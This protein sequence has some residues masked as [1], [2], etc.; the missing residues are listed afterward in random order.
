MHA[1]NRKETRR[2]VHIPA[3]L[4]AGLG[5]PLRDCMLTDISEHG[6]RLAF[7][8]PKEAPDEF[9]LLLA[10]RGGAYR[11][12]RVVWRAEKELG[13]EFDMAK[14]SHGSIDSLLSGPAGD[15][16][17]ALSGRDSR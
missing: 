15:G 9:T 1:D 5:S 11:Q 2:P 12:C 14:S 13:V 3:K 17:L 4:F 10:P 8:A 7:E 16:P 6:A